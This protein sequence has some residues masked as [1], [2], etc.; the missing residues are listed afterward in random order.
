M[1]A[2]Q[3]IDILTLGEWLSPVCRDFLPD[4]KKL[5]DTMDRKGY[6]HE[7]FGLPELTVRIPVDGKT[8][9][10]GK[11]KYQRRRFDMIF[12]VKPHYKAHSEEIFTVGFETKVSLSDLK[13]DEKFLDYIGHVNYFFFSVPADLVQD[14]EEKIKSDA[15]E[16]AGKSIGIFDLTNQEIIKM[17]ES[18]KNTI[19]KGE[20]MQEIACRM[21]FKKQK[22]A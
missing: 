1:T 16:E 15:P 14:T 8:T 9:K 6:K 12:V 5:F 17:P 22:K 19:R 7:S 20:F 11:P 2:K 21:L 10:H 4:T 18:M 3:A 13:Q